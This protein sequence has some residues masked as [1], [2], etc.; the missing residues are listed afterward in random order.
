MKNETKTNERTRIKFSSPHYRSLFLSL[1]F[2]FDFFYF[3]VLRVCM[4]QRNFFMFLFILRWG[5]LLLFFPILRYS[6]ISFTA[7]LGFIIWAPHIKATDKRKSSYGNM[8]ELLCCEKYCQIKLFLKKNY[9]Y[10]EHK[11]EIKCQ[12]LIWNT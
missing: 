5:K 6:D 3:C 4:C 12:W 11:L 1:E 2:C 10:L 9:R 8:T 7:V